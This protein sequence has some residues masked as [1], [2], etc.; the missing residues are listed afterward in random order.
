MGKLLY[1]NPFL[2]NVPFWSPW[3]HQKTFGF[4]KLT[5]GSKRNIGKKRVNWI[6]APPKHV[7]IMVKVNHKQKSM[8]FWG[9]TAPKM[10]FSIKDFFSKCDQIS[11]FLRIWSHLPQKSLM[12]NS[13][14]VECISYE[15][16]MMECLIGSWRRSYNCSKLVKLV[17][18][19]LKT[20]H[21]I[22]ILF[23]FRFQIL[24]QLIYKSSFFD[25][26]WV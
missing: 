24:P 3:K 16:S 2:P 7:R 20:L 6:S 25:Y 18:C 26:F 1:F 10:K 9:I 15:T 14:F 11:T 17:S 21:K 5:G 4:L 19:V 23:F 8:K 12:E 22:W 13:I